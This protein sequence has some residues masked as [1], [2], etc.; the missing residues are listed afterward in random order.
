MWSIGQQQRIGVFPCCYPSASIVRRH[1][2]HARFWVYHVPSSVADSSQVPPWHCGQ[3][4]ASAR[5]FALLISNSVGFRLVLSQ[6]VALEIT[7]GPVSY[8][9]LD[10]YKRQLL[11]AAV[12]KE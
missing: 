12:S 6:S 3:P 11:G 9:H 4:A 10:V 2:N 7:F 1:V 8:T 5:A